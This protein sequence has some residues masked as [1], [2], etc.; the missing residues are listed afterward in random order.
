MLVG[1]FNRISATKGGAVWKGV[2]FRTG[3]VCVSG[4]VDPLPN[5]CTNR[6]CEGHPAAKRYWRPLNSKRSLPVLK[7]TSESEYFLQTLQS[8]SNHLTP[9]CACAARG[10]YP[11]AC[12]SKGLFRP[13][14][15][16]I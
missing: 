11:T 3:N 10:N 9:R 6:I 15:K 1:V 4:V 2:L 5:R 14:L 13:V 12:T 7:W 8:K 16:F